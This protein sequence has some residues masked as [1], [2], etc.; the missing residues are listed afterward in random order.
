MIKEIF[1]RFNF[2]FISTLFLCTLLWITNTYSQVSAPQI[3]HSIR[4]DTSP[5]LRDMAEAPVS[6]TPWKN[7]VIPIFKNESK[8]KDRYQKDKSLQN[9]MGTRGT[10]SILQS[11]DG[12]SAGPYIPPDC[13]GDVGLNHYMEMVNIQFQIWDKTGTSLLGPL[14]LGTLWSGFPG[15]WSSS[16]NDGD[17][18][19][20]YDEAADR[21]VATQFSLPN[22]GSSPNYILVAVSQTSDPTGSW[23]RYGFEFPDFPDYPKYGVWPD[24]YY[25]SANHF[26]GSAVGTTNAAFE[27][28]AMLNGDPAQM[29]LFNTS[30]SISWS[31]LPSDWNGTN[32]P[33]AGSPAR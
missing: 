18:V 4:N 17:P 12:V 3:F 24:G 13:S 1:P 7:G 32:T 9:T 31:L 19:I 14:N 27:R 21:W 30:L 2:F 11:W 29:V 6:P 22:Y 26:S 10:T 33:P 8:F 25:V 5:P 15:P 23:Y 20:L 16:L 28:E